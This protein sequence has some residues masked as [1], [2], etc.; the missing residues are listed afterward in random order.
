MPNKNLLVSLMPLLFLTI[1]LIGSAC[2]PV[3]IERVSPDDSSSIPFE[4]TE[5]DDTS[6]AFPIP[7]D[8]LNSMGAEQSESD[9]NEDIQEEHSTPEIATQGRIRLFVNGNGFVRILPSGSREGDTWLF[10]VGQRI[11]LTAIPNPGWVF[12]EWSGSV[13]EH[14]AQVFVTVDNELVVVATFEEAV[15]EDPDEPIDD[16]VV[17]DVFSF[18]SIEDTEVFQTLIAFSRSTIA[19]ELAD[20]LREINSQFGA[21]GLSG[22]SAQ[23][24]ARCEATQRAVDS[25]REST[26]NELMRIMDTSALTP[27][28]ILE[29][30]TWNRTM[31]PDAPRQGYDFETQTCS[32]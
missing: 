14:V 4:S 12:A 19:R 16:F 13:V 31:Y 3:V 15:E 10:P 26:W 1:S 28:Q 18:L 20:E 29:V 24:R 11:S 32:C 23:C 25:Q 5:Q 21:N 22:S 27:V 8:N 30:E 6:E 17:G 7:V 9:P 2:S